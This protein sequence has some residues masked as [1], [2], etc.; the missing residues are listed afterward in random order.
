MK[1]MVVEGSFKKDKKETSRMQGISKITARMKQ[2]MM[3]WS[4]W[5]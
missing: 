5:N 2:P 3:I 1:K 4:L